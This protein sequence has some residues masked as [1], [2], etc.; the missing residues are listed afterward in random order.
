VD[1][2][3]HRIRG[4]QTGEPQAK[5]ENA[6]KQHRDP[7]E[8]FDSVRAYAGNSSRDLPAKPELTKLTVAKF[9]RWTRNT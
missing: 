4:D 9:D 2:S 7:L 5:E 8:V 3:A 1:E 6:K